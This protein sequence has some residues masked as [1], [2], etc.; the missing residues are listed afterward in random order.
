MAFKSKLYDGEQVMTR[1]NRAVLSQP[2]NGAG[3]GFEDRRPISLG[4]ALSLT[5]FPAD[6][7]IDRSE[8]REK[9]EQIESDQAR[10]SEML[11]IANV[12][13]LHQGT[14]NY[15][16]A[17]AVVGA[18]QTLRLRQ[19]LPHVDLSPASVAS[20]ISGFSDAPGFGIKALVRIAEVGVCSTDVWPANTF[21]PFFGTTVP[22]NVLANA[23]KVKVAE[24]WDLN[25]SN[26]LPAFEDIMSGLLL[27]FPVDVGFSWWRHE[28]L[29][30]DP[31][32]LPGNRF[33]VRIRNSW[34]NDWGVKGGFM[35][36]DEELFG[37]SHPTNTASIPRV[38]V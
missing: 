36:L 20:P 3:T 23:A 28:V 22:P 18:V 19:G 37:G 15:C 31:V 6:L 21:K 33:G 30:C 1:A 10:L 9:I 13:V 5:E 17:N 25:K 2:P 12:R 7:R 34:G 29:A 27:G 8:W 16:W 11:L 26:Q 4:N 38:V 35:V 14:T 24:W 32:A